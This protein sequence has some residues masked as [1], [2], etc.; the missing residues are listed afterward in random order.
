MNA[1]IDDFFKGDD[2]TA[3]RRAIE[4]LDLSKYGNGFRYIPASMMFDFIRTNAGTLRD[5]TISAGDAPPWLSE[6]KALK[7]FTFHDCKEFDL[8]VQDLPA[9]EVLNY[10]AAGAMKTITCHPSCKVQALGRPVK[11]V[12]LQTDLQTILAGGGSFGE[13]ILRSVSEERYDAIYKEIE[14]T[15]NNGRDLGPDQLR[16]QSGRLADMTLAEKDHAV[17]GYI[18]FIRQARDAEWLSSQAMQSIVYEGF[19]LKPY[20]GISRYEF[21][22]G[23][24]QQLHGTDLPKHRVFRELLRVHHF[25]ESQPDMAALQVAPVYSLLASMARED[26]YDLEG[27]ARMTDDQLRALIDKLFDVHG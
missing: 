22:S 16:V 11:V 8:N 15:I 9:L 20:T 25:D 21:L 12:N 18:G 3:P 17:H 10:S 5:L 6:L 23:L 7:K 27:D 4:S 13:N 26:V 24:A 1:L 2:S 14:R 19:D